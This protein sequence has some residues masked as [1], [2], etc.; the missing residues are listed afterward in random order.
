MLLDCRA[1]RKKDL[2]CTPFTYDRVFA[3][4]KALPAE[5]EHIVVLLGSFD[6]GLVRNAC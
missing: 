2:I 4:L 5:V 1:E 6:P 3:A